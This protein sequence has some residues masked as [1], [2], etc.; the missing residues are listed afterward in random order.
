MEKIAVI[1]DGGWGT[2][3][4]VLLAKKGCRVSL[5]GPFP[6]YVD[7][8]NKRRENIKFL[9]S[10]AIP[11][12]IEISSDIEKVTQEANIVVLVV[13]SHFMREVAAKLKKIG[14]KDVILLSATKGVEN[15]TLMRM[16]E[17]IIDVLGRQEIAVI[18][19]PSIAQEV[20]KEIPTTVV[21]S[22]QDKK[23]A[24]EIQEVFTTDRFRV[25]TN[26]DIIGVEL[27][28]ALKN[29]IAI[30][31]GITDGLGFG[32]NAKAAL[33][34]RG[35]VEITRLGVAMGAKRETFSGLSG[36]G[37]LV[38]TCI[39]PYGRNR[40]VG[41][42]IGKGKKLSEILKNMEMVAEGVKT[43]KSAYELRNKFKIEM[44]I[45]KEVY[46]VLYEDKDPIKAVNELMGRERKEEFKT[47]SK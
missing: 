12:E 32:T 8:L 20:A 18:S 7:F 38:T 36:I 23:I 4:A 24:N 10:V 28:G 29:I 40:M 31:A 30:A 34:S 41:E 19:G 47:Q 37:D 39:S 44:P 21:V 25:Y 35:L 5:W 43:S 13:P 1:G 45:T 26:S 33:L 6:D 16:S 42:E 27:G 14:L 3:L 9:P 17:V 11:A 46:C 2:T 15:D 22:S